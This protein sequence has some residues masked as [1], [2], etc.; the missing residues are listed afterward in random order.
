MRPRLAVCALAALA[1]LGLTA[2]TLSGYGE[3]VQVELPA[4]DAVVNAPG[5]KLP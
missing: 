5:G 2:W 3:D 4:A 1:A